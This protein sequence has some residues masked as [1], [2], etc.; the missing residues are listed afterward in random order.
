[1]IACHLFKI[2]GSGD[3][4]PCWKSLTH[5]VQERLAPVPACQYTSKMR[6]AWFV[7]KC[8]RTAG[9]QQGD[10]IA[11]RVATMGE[12]TRVRPHISGKD[13]ED[14][15]LCYILPIPRLQFV[16]LHCVSPHDVCKWVYPRM[17]AYHFPSLCLLRHNVCMPLCVC[18]SLLRPSSLFSALRAQNEPPTTQKQRAD[19]GFFIWLKDYII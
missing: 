10:I 8:E 5:P 15:M 2:S 13:G 9:S 17:T 11:C 19:G 14:C 7:G 6:V 1:M 18:V 3:P 16:C 12:V 4:I